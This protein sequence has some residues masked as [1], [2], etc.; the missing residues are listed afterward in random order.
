MRGSLVFFHLKSKPLKWKTL[1]D[2]KNKYIG[3]VLGYSYGKTFDDAVKNGELKVEYV[4]HDILNFKKLLAGRID[5]YPSEIDVGYNF[6]HEHF[7]AEEA[8]LFTHHPQPLTSS[9][10]VLLLSKA[11]HSNKQRIERFN[12]GLKRLIDSG[13]VDQYV[14][15]SRQGDYRFPA[16]TVPE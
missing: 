3:L 14:A 1:A 7:T 16:P 12:K 2:I 13:K 11:V 10:Y 6:I 4:A 15:E 5:A 8:E 9:P